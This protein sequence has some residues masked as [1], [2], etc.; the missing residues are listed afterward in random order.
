MERIVPR[1]LKY[2]KGSKS[3]SFS[4]GPSISQQ[5]VVEAATNSCLDLERFRLSLKI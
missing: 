3:L 1:V 4:L 2:Q 5:F